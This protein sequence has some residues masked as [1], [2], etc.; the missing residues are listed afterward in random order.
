[1]EYWEVC[2]AEAFEEQGIAATLEQ[3]MAVAS[4]VEGGHENYGLAH[5]HDCIPNPLQAENDKLRCELR[6]EQDKRTCPVCK[7]SGENRTAGGTF[8][9]ISSCWKCRGEGRC[10]P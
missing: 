5:G 4:W 10:A 2:I 7:G 8:V 1:M 3:I 6:A 9:S